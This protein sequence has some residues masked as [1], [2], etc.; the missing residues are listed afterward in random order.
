MKQV[1]STAIHAYNNEPHAVSA[2]FEPTTQIVAEYWE[3]KRSS[4]IHTGSIVSRIRAGF[5]MLFNLGIDTDMPFREAKLVRFTNMLCVFIVLGIVFYIP[6]SLATGSYMLAAIETVDAA[7]V[8]SALYFS[9]RKMFSAAK[10]MLIGVVNVFIYINACYIG[11]AA[12][13]QHFYVLINIVPFLVF[14]LNQYKHIAAAI[15]ITIGWFIVYQLTYHHWE[16]YNLPIEVQNG[17][18]QIGTWL[19]FVLFAL[20]IYMLAKNNYE[21]EEELAGSN[22]ILTSQAVEL[23]RSNEDLEQFAYIISHDLRVP[24]RNITN[25]LTLLERR[26]APALNNEAKEFINYS[27]EGAKRL[28]RLIEDL[29]SYSKVGR[30]LPPAQ[31]VDSGELLKTIQF[32]MRDKA[33]RANHKITISDKMPI[34]E[35]VHSTMIYHVF[36]NLI[37]NGLKFNKNEKPEVAVNVKTD[38]KQH[39]FEVRDN[40]IGIPMEYKNKLFQMFKRLHTEQEFQGTGMGLAI[41]KRI[42]NFYGGEV[43]FESETGKGT[44]FFFTIPKTIA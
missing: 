44:S 16:D 21:I 24:L 23:K 43:W 12:D 26:H 30:N 8:A 25:F 14:R 1:L 39:T 27:V 10:F 6:F 33:L 19:D 11:H 13:V 36:Q 37:T 31:S 7:F 28:E 41:C 38:N 17:T 42:V 34:L 2:E 29:L 40:G 32:E 22:R 20:G 3:S 9:S 35:N 5:E 18:R 15:T 4:S